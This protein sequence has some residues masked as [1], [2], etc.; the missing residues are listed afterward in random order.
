MRLAVLA[1][2][3]CCL[4]HLLLYLLHLLPCLAAFLPHRFC[5]R[6]INLIAQVWHARA[7]ASTVLY[8]HLRP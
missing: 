8:S 7:A 5:M 2:P 1:M 4:L 3:A 6:C